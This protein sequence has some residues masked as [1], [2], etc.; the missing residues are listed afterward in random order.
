MKILYFER[1][2]G[3]SFSY[4]NEI[5][6][7]LGKQNTLYQFADWSPI[8]GPEVDINNVL[9]RCPEKPDVILFGFGWTDCS[10][11]SPNVV[12]NLDKCD[13]PVSV[14][15]NKEYSAL[16]KKLD[17]VKNIN[18][19]VA[20]TVHHDYDYYSD[21]TNV[22]FYQVPFAVNEKVFKRFEKEQYDCDFGFSGVIRPEQ[23]NDW[24]TK[25]VDRSKT[26]KDINFS[27]SQH[28]HDTLEAYARRLNRAKSWLSTTG[29]A[30]LG[31]TLLTCNRF[32]RVY[33]DLFE[34]DKHCIMFESLDEL[35]E[36]L[37]YYLKN[38]DE[39]MKIITDAK[40]HVL[41]NHTWMHRAEKIT[42]TL[43]ETLG[44]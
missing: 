28:R 39:R 4:Y 23:T 6:K 19:A 35:E 33:D 25:I 9:K 7:A 41:N 29:P 27:F 13:I 14:I 2:Y 43:K 44:K 8:G 36:K 15:L 1:S 16:Q 12:K 32:D 5:K 18:P 11:E 10:E 21:V 34:E 31:T 17:W 20:F 42:N 24:R 3:N 26:W 30:D 22:P 37:R 40:D 38:D